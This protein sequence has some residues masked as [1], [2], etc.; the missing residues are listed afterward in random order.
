[1]AGIEGRQRRGFCRRRAFYSLLTGCC[2]LNRCAFSV[3]FSVTLSANLVCRTAW[4]T[5]LRNALLACP[6]TL[7]G[8]SLRALERSGFGFPI[9]WVFIF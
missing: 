3:T 9:G 4:L 5:S 7:A 2:I 6:K 8:P 1:M